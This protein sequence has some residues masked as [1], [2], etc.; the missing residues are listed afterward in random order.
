MSNL[1]FI[2]LITASLLHTF[3]CI[4]GIPTFDLYRIL[5]GGTTGIEPATLTPTD[6]Q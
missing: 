6:S 4:E 3:K 5:M 1:F 2:T